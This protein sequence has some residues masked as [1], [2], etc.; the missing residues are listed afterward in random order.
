M[1]SGRDDI[2]LRSSLLLTPLGNRAMYNR[3]LLDTIL[4]KFFRAGNEERYQ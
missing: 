4:N 2:Y 1:K 3:F